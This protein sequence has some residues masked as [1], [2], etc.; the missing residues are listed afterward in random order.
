MADQMSSFIVTHENKSNIYINTA[1]NK[2]SHII[3]WDVI[4][5]PFPKFNG[6]LTKLTLKLGHGWVIGFDDYTD[7]LWLNDIKQLVL[8]TDQ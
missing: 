2:Q 7:L 8:P 1:Q 6:G 5:H 3:I 4:T